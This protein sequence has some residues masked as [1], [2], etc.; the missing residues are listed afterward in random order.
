[1]VVW[2][3]NSD[4]AVAVCDSLGDS[5]RP[6]PFTITPEGGQ[7]PMERTESLSQLIQFSRKFLTVYRLSHE[8]HTGLTLFNSHIRSADYPHT[9]SHTTAI[10]IEFISRLSVRRSVVNQ[11]SQRTQANVFS[12]FWKMFKIFLSIFYLA[13]VSASFI[14]PYPRFK[15]H[16]DGNDPGDALYLT[17]YIERGDVALVKSFV[18]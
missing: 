3:S 13:T 6:S 11:K 2:L 8:D 12:F 10:T 18:I 7:C 14:N 15:H 17:E 1:M 9:L 16:Y 5:S 4:W